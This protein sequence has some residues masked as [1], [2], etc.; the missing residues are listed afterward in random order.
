MNSEFQLAL[1][2]QFQ[3]NLISKKWESLVNQEFQGNWQFPDQ[4]ITTQDV[5]VKIKNISL[6][7]K[8]HLEK[9]SLQ[10]QQTV[11]QLTSKNLEA[12]LTI[13]EVSVDHIVERV[14]G[15]IIGRF[16][17]Q[18]SCKNVVMTM[19]PGKGSMSMAVAPSVGSTNAAAL[20]QSVDVGWAPGSWS[21]TGI[22][23][24]GVEGFADLLK[25]EIDKIANDSVSFIQ[26]KKDL[27]RKYVQDYLQD[28]K[29]DFSSP[30]QLIV[31]R[32]DI[33]VLMKVDEYKDQGE[34]GALIKG[35]LQIDFLNT[36][37]SEVKNLVLTPGTAPMS[38]GEAQIILPK[39]FIKEVLLK[40]YS[41]NA[42]LHKITSDKLPGF[43]SLMSSRFMQ[44]FVWPA[45]RDYS[46]STKF[47]FDVYSN[48]DMEIQGGG[49]QYQAKANFYARMQAPRSGQYV[50]FVNWSVPFN[51]KINLKVENGKASATLVN[52]SLGMTPYYDASYVAKYSPNRRILYG[53][54]R[55]KIIS[56]IWGQTM[57]M[58]IPKI[59][60]M[61][62]VSL[63]VKKVL[64][65]NN[66]DITLQLT[67]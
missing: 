67:P 62:G 21:S 10:N 59:P 44:F 11:L 15:G 23:C 55:D 30:R 22:Q 41:A 64:A 28:I 29:L 36:K 32:P 66:Q 49:L 58:E 7:V 17:I 5:P 39:D 20:V 51:S 2:R 3:E 53:T 61:E 48:K 13:G 56:G 37:D 1:P 4:E 19:I 24:E 18:A 33:S 16:R 8:T 26:P 40:A 38:S 60:L 63:K 25:T 9:P 46:K 50:P 31:S 12:Q 6:K 14:V 57:T 54:I 43:G 52:P 42:W 27:I 34:A 65:P 35:H 47:L 45:L